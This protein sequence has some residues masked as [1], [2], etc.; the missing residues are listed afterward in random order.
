MDYLATAMLLAYLKSSS[1]HIFTDERGTLCVG[2]V[3]MKPQRTF[4]ILLGDEER[5]HF[6]IAR[7][8][9]VLKDFRLHGLALVGHEVNTHKSVDVIRISVWRYDKIFG[10]EYRAE[11]LAALFGQGV[12]SDVVKG[13]KE[14][15]LSSHKG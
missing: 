1:I 14:I 8:L 15:R 6:L 11:Q 7:V 4:D 12:P 13:L 5:E 10:L 3:E 9:R 2:V